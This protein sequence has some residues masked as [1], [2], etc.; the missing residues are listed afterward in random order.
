MDDVGSYIY[1]IENI[2]SRKFQ[3]SSLP[4]HSTGTQSA[5]CIFSRLLA[6]R[7]NTYHIAF[8]PT[9]S[10]DMVCDDV[11]NDAECEHITRVAIESAEG[12]HIYL[13]RVM[14]T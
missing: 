7:L 11:H 9:T 10:S 14:Y 6:Y 1:N 2:A 5:L 3:P 8:E 13:F 12:K 4:Q